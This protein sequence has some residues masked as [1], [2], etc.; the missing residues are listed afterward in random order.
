MWPRCYHYYLFCILSQPVFFLV[1][2]S[3]LT[4][5]QGLINNNTSIS[6]CNY[7]DGSYLFYCLLSMYSLVLRYCERL[8]LSISSSEAEKYSFHVFLFFSELSFDTCMTTI[9]ATFV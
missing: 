9:S 8:T 6:V 3:Y 5:Y 7:E 2:L 4:K 1:I